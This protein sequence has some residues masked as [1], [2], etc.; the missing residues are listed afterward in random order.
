MVRVSTKTKAIYGVALFLV[1]TIGI[2]VAL[3]LL[4][5]FDSAPSK[6]IDVTELNNLNYKY[7]VLIM[8]HELAPGGG[9]PEG[10]VLSDCSTQRNLNQEGIQLASMTGKKLSSFTRLA[11][12]I[13]SSKWC[14]CLETAT[15]IALEFNYT[16]EGARGLNSF[17]QSSIGFTKE[18][19]MGWLN[20]DILD[21]LK[22]VKVNDR[23]HQTL[24]VT[25]QVTVEALT[26]F[27][28]DSGGIVAYDS[29]TGDAARLTL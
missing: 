13:Y 25:H 5:L 29:I 14:R 4:G 19:C 2:L 3:N 24:L 27:K 1:A 23:V 11:P 15:Q 21:R 6:S 12:T 18:E 10:F 26:G 22:Q 9:D 17:Y 8:R 7:D 28:V 20:T 16:V